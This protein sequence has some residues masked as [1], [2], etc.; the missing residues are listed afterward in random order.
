MTKDEQSP[1]IEELAGRI[2]KA[3]DAR[4]TANSAPPQPSPIGLALRMGVEMVASLFVGAAMGWLL[5]R[6]LDTG[7]W[8]LLV[9]LLLGGA[10]G[11]LNVYKT[12]LRLNAQAEEDQENTEGK[13]D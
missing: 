2:R 9:C 6:W 11:M 7:P 3:R 1:S 4:P 10:G 5:D 12:G 8:L 13:N